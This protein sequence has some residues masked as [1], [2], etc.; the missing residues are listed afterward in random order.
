M[1]IQDFHETLF[2]MARVVIA[3]G[4]VMGWSTALFLKRLGHQ[5]PVTVVE[6]GGESHSSTARSAGGIRHQFTLE[7]NVRLSMFGTE[8]LRSLPT[9]LS[10]SFREGGYLFLASSQGGADALRRANE[11]Q[12]RCGAQV[13]SSKRIF[14]SSPCFVQVSLLDANATTARWPFLHGEDVALAGFGEAGEGW[15]DPH[16]LRAS[17]AVQAQAVTLNLALFSYVVVNVCSF[18]QLGAEKLLDTVT[19]VV[20][21]KGRKVSGVALQSGR[22]LECDILVNALGPSCAE[23]MWSLDPSFNLPVRRRKRCIFF[24]TCKDPMPL[25]P[26]V[27]LRFGFWGKVSQLGQVIDPSGVYFRPEGSGY[28]TGCSPSEENDP[29]VEPGDFEVDHDMWEERLWPALVKKK[30]KKKKKQKRNGAFVVL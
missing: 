24:F 26:M 8:Y 16:L 14:S 9:S 12:R 20:P 27:C 2:R 5:G 25:C 21:G 1:K 18:V 22:N 19:R 11:L 23:L 4:G 28:I 13:K 6:R 3:G 29:D 10:C 7:E 15:L 17:F 30:K